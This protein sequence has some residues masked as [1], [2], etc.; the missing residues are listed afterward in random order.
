MRGMIAELSVSKKFAALGTILV[1]L[2][3]GPL[4]ANIVTMI[5]L[6]LFGM[7]FVVAIVDFFVFF[8][9]YYSYA[10]L[11]SFVFGAVMAAYGWFKGRPPILFALVV[12]SSLFV[13][14][15]Y[16]AQ[17]E[18][19]TTLTKPMFFVCMAAASACW[20]AFR[21]FWHKAA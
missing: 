13:I 18:S 1:C 14:K 9:N 12:A 11:S 10:G 16:Y 17:N 21:K 2:L 15:G 4:V 5:M 20:F 19:F 7:K 3:M 8:P 6:A